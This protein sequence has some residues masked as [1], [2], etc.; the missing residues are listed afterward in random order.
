MIKNHSTSAEFVQ[1]GFRPEST[2]SVLAISHLEH[3]EKWTN[4]LKTVSTEIDAI[5]L[6]RFSHLEH[7]EK[8]SNLLKT[9]FVR[10]LRNP[11]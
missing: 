5:S 3:V 2:K 9:E 10:N 7:V 1:D 4:F 11:F 6:I 8:C